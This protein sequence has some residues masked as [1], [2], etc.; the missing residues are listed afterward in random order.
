VKVNN[1]KVRKFRGGGADMGDPGKAEARAA[2]GYG[3]IAGPDRSKVSPQ[4]EASHQRSIASARGSNQQTTPQATQ[5][6]AQNQ[7]RGFLQNI[8]YQTQQLTANLL[9]IGKPKQKNLMDMRV[10]GREI[11]LQN[12]NLTGS[13]RDI[14]TEQDI[15]SA[16]RQQ[17]AYATER[18]IRKM[19]PSFTKV[20]ATL[21]SKPLA[22]GTIRNRDFFTNQVLGNTKKGSLYGDKSFSGLTLGQRETMYGQYAK[23][24]MSRKIDAFGRPVRPEGGGAQ[25]PSLCPDGTTPP[26][27]TPVTQIKKPVST[28][29]TFLSGFQSYDDGGEV[30][31]SGN[32]DKDLL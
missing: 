16:F 17:G 22:K 11:G 26:C 21:L 23:D 30:I 25:Q 4:Q 6:T 12:Q 29:N 18:G 24:R 5:K 28:P 2:A 8:G 9:N 15:Q 14:K 32:V 20:G 10:T 19:A 3:S 13:A 31:I 1:R 27:K 7:N